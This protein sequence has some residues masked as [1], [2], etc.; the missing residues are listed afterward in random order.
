MPL[1][2][3]SLDLSFCFVA[4]KPVFLWLNSGPENSMNLEAHIKENMLIFS[5]GSW[6]KQASISTH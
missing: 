6:G 4:H 5:C 3:L 1:E 2:A